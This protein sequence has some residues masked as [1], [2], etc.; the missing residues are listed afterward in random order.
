MGRFVRTIPGRGIEQSW[1]YIPADPVLRDHAASIEHELRYSRRAADELE[2]GFEPQD[3]RR[4][5]ERAEEVAFVPLSADVAPQ[6]TLFGPAP[7][8]SPTP[9][10]VT[11]MPAMA[12]PAA[13]FERREILRSERHRLVSELT[14]R[15]GASQREINAWLNR[16]LGIT[17]VKDASLTD[18]ERSVELLVGRLT[19]R[20]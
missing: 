13:G 1:L 4:R 5:T 3:D 2:E 10:L 14:R 20:R 15:D 19:S 16:K 17:S 18:L 6:M 11:P 7:T 12:E 9:T 8:A